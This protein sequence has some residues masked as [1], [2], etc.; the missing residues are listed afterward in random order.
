MNR[1]F[2]SD[3]DATAKA[4]VPAS[5]NS[6]MLRAAE[7]APKDATSR[8]RKGK[9]H[10]WKQ[11]EESRRVIC[12]R[13]KLLSTKICTMPLA[14]Q[15]N[16]AQDCPTDKT[17]AKN[18][19]TCSSVTDVSDDSDSQITSPSSKLSAC[20]FGAAVEDVEIRRN[21]GDGS[22]LQWS[23]ASI[24]G[25]ADAP[26]DINLL[27]PV[28][29]SRLSL[30]D[31]HALSGVLKPSAENNYPA[32][33]DVCDQEVL[34]RASVVAETPAGP[35]CGPMKTCCGLDG[36]E[37]I[38]AGNQINESAS[39]CSSLPLFDSKPSERAAQA[40]VVPETPLKSEG[41]QPPQAC[42]GPLTAPAVTAADDGADREL[43]GDVKCGWAQEEALLTEFANVELDRAEERCC[44]SN[45]AQNAKVAGESEEFS[46]SSFTVLHGQKSDQDHVIHCCSPPITS[47]PTLQSALAFY[48]GH[49]QQVTARDI[50]HFAFPFCWRKF[51]NTF[52]ESSCQTSLHVWAEEFSPAGARKFIVASCDAFVKY[53][54][55]C[56]ALPSLL[57][58]S[59]QIFSRPALF[60]RAKALLR[61][62]SRG[63]SLQ[64]VRR[65]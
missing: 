39:P 35:S 43:D 18:T 45:F 47:F 42:V 38:V 56:R 49:P 24:D 21:C 64:H 60:R 62:H 9:S 58:Q 10:K 41:C 34:A 46:S 28:Q 63:P 2:F 19:S 20:S 44:K 52:T 30:C 1:L 40:A 23:P 7:P 17:A 25:S 16:I 61:S 54:L 50:A 55:F 53:L 15:S 57:S 11:E 32:D 29:M 22:D 4:A 3:A 27:S 5:F 14:T 33:F 65:R 37:A 36:G 48:S 26:L 8:N 59:L 51:G 31:L 12:E 13:N 6:K